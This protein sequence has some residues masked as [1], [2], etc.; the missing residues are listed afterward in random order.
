MDESE[1]IGFY[2][3]FGPVGGSTLGLVAIPLTTLSYRSRPD[4]TVRPE[5]SGPGQVT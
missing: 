2:P 1:P 4:H 3:L 5:S